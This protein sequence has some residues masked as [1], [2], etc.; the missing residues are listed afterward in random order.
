MGRKTGKP[1]AAATPS[2]GPASSPSHKTP[3]ASMRAL[4]RTVRPAGIFEAPGIIA[5]PAAITKAQQGNSC[6]H[7]PARRSHDLT[8]GIYHATTH[9][10][11][12]EKPDQ[13]EQKKRPWAPPKH[14]TSSTS[15]ASSTR[16]R[17]RPPQIR[18]PVSGDSLQVFVFKARVLPDTDQ[19]DVPRLN[20]SDFCCHL[21]HL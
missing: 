15:R 4:A 19:L 7:C 13:V 5:R 17:S 14:S 3:L 2:P 1:P 9:S 10:N 8:R 20:H 12:R 21:L 16:L 6:L 18:L 11:A